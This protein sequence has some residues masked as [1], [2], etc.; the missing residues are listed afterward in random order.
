MSG[1]ATI[2]EL[3]LPQA[4]KLATERKVEYAKAAKLPPPE[5]PVLCEMTMDTFMADHYFPHVKAAQA[6]LGS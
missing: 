3:T 5:K 6:K 2:K 4:R 1:L